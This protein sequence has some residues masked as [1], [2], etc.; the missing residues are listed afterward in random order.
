[1]SFLSR[2]VAK[3][4]VYLVVRAAKKAEDLYQDRRKG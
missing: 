3:V 1:M 2:I 4:W